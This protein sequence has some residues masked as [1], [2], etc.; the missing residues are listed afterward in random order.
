MLVCRGAPQRRRENYY[1]V[2]VMIPVGLFN[3]VSYS[4]FWVDA[5]ALPARTAFVLLPLLIV[6]NQV[7]PA[8][9]G[10]AC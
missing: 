7:S 8:P 9:P 4:S 1:V 2:Q 3:L 10:P 6:V 5:K